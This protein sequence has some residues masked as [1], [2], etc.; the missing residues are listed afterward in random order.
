MN[1]T[2]LRVYGSSTSLSVWLFDFAQDEY[3]FAQGV[4]PFDFAQDEHDFAQDECHFDF[5]QDE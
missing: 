3:D 4:W 1:T 5:A 2:S